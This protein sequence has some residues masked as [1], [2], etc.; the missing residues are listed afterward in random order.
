MKLKIRCLLSVLIFSTIT[1][2]FAQTELF[3]KRI[4]KSGDVVMPYRLHVP[5][6]FDST[7]R[8]PLILYF[9]GAGERGTD[10]E[11]TLKHGVQNFVQSEYLE[12]YP[13]FILV[14]QCMPEYRWVEVLWS[15]PSHTRPEQM[16]IPMCMAVDI[17]DLI[18][19]YYPVDTNRIDRKSVV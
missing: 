15:L 7:M 13:C 10:N 9:H 18:I 6:N 11:I 2:C 1:S 17:L 16:S 8:Y 3:E 12:K 4:Y 19:E 5:E 14:P